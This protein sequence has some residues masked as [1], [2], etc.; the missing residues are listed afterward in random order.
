[1]RYR[2]NR[3]GLAAVLWAV[4]FFLAGQAGLSLALERWLPDLRDREYAWKMHLLDG[5]RQKEPDRPLVLF[6]GS[7]RTQGAFQADRLDGEPGPDGNPLA[8]FNL[9]QSKSGPV[10]T[11]IHCQELLDRGVR[12]RLLLVEVLPFL[13]NEAA[14]GRVSEEDWVGGT[15]PSLAQLVRFYPYCSMRGRILTDWLSARLLP[16]YYHRSYIMDYYARSWASPATRLVSHRLTSSN[17]WYVGEGMEGWAP[18]AGYCRLLQH[19][20][21]F[22]WQLKYCLVAPGPAQALRDLVDRCRREHVP[23]AL[24]LLPEPS[25]VRG[26]YSPLVRAQIG[27]LMDEMKQAHGVE[28]IDARDW[29]DD[30]SFNDA[31]HL[32]PWGAYQFTDQINEEIHRLL[33]ETAAAD[34]VASAP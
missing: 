10:R 6:V 27:Q 4:V 29:I 2:M 3:R 22:G 30:L 23:V 33:K 31:L 18:M 14:P 5:L 34:Q 8:A 20:Q 19:W 13:F 11:A 16:A 1:M 28:V 15:W 21:Q 32:L 9:G 17:G 25:V 26:W 7:S 24:V 12:P